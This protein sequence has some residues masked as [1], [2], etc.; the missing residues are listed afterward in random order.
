M[1]KTVQTDLRIFVLLLVL[2]LVPALSG[3]NRLV[4]LEVNGADDP[5]NINYLANA[6]PIAL[7]MIGYAVFCVFGTFQIAPMFRKRHIVGHR[8]LGRFLV[9]IGL[10]AAIT[11]IWMSLTYPPMIANGEAVSYVRIVFGAGMVVC[12][13][14][15]TFAIRRRKL[16]AHQRWMLRSLAIAFGASTQALVAIPW[17]FLIG[18]PQG[19]PWAIAMLLAWVFNLIVAEIFADSQ[20]S[21]AA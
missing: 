2:C 19:M 3:A 16:V 14:L 6:A 9:P 15:G 21:R 11:G 20:P 12:L 5:E 17:F 10:L 4:S 8:Y 13:C 1:Q 18:E 7:H